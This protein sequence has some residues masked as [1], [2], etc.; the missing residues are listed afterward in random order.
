M[1]PRPEVFLPVEAHG[2]LRLD[3]PTGQALDLEAAGDTLRID[4][5]G[6]REARAI[7]PLSLRESRRALRFLANML[8]MAGLTL[9]VESAGKPV[10]RL[11]SVGKPSW[12]ARLLG[13]GPTRI[14]FSAI[15]F[16]LGRP[17]G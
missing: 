17:A 16:Y 1:A 2:I 13:L 15:R 14:P 9:R 10:L 3:A 4:L 12:L 8:S 7:M 6:L 5:P 11:G